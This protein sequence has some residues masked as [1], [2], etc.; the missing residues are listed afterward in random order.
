M[1]FVWESTTWAA[2]SWMPPW[3]LKRLTSSTPLGLLM[4]MVTLSCWLIWI[5]SYGNVVPSVRFTWLSAL[6]CMGQSQ[7]LPKLY[8][9]P[10]SMNWSLLF[11]P[12]PL[13]LLLW[14]D[15]TLM[16]VL[17][18]LQVLRKD[19][20][21][22]F[23][24]P[25]SFFLM[26]MGGQVQPIFCISC[27]AFWSIIWSFGLLLVVHIVMYSNV[28]LSTLI[29]HAFDTICIDLQHA[30]KITLQSHSNFIFIVSDCLLWCT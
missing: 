29:M 17:H 2:K 27:V 6:L 15:V 24:F 7:I 14:K 9:L 21:I 3:K 26:S 1:N 23:D 4:L 28:C 20:P 13:L 30:L 5:G 22:S 10:I 19:V 25:Q 16:T 12:L 8:P 18:P 11:L